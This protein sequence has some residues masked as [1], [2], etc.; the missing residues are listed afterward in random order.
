MLTAQLWSLQIAAGDMRGAVSPPLSPEQGF[1]MGPFG[2]VS[3]NFGDFLFKEPKQ[4]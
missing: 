2:E 3:R 1:V 4:S